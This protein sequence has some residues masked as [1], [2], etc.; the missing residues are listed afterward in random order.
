[1]TV[2][3]VDTSA[4]VAVAFDERGGATCA[5]RLDSFLRLVSS[6]L[7]EA[8]LRA[9]FA[10]ERRRFASDLVSDIEWILPDRRLTRE[11]E[12]VVEAGYL[13]G[14]DLWH[15]ATAL[16][17]APVPSTISFITLDS[18]QRAVASA[19]GFDV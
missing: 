8:E 4:L 7:L 17:V 11:F 5:R 12:A 6:N 14:A 16:Y 18:R 2:A 15:V 3:Y 13:R 9:V 19:L 10:R 1:M